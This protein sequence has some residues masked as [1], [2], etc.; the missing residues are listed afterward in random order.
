MFNDKPICAVGCFYNEN[1]FAKNKIIYLEQ[2]AMHLE[3]KN[4]GIEEQFIKLIILANKSNSYKIR[5]KNV[6][7]A[8]IIK[9]LTNNENF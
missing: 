8:E 7:I 9:K 6:K 4:R 1:A 3:N 5:S 2:L